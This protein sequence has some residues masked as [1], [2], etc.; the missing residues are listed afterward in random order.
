M[1][2]LLYGATGWIGFQ[3]FQLLKE[4]NVE[5]V[6]SKVR[7]ENFGDIS[8]ELNK[9]KPTHVL[10]AA[11]LTGPKN[12]DWCED[13]KDQVMSVNVIGTSVLA[14]ECNKRD[15]HLTFI[16][17]G[18]IYKYDEQHPIGFPGF[19][20]EDKPNFDES[21]YSKTKIMVQKILE[22]YNNV[23]ILRIRM[24]LAD[25]LHSRN[26]I[27]K[28]T[29]YEKVINIPNSMTVLSELLPIA[30]DMSIKSKTGTYNFTNPGAISHNQILTLYKEY[31]DPS[32]TWQNF[33]VEE[34]DKIL[35]AARSNN[36]LDVTK[37]TSEYHVDFI[38]VAIV[39]LFERMKNNVQ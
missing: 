4:K 23:L 13:H 33:T 34:Q 31:I 18:C 1:K 2:V 19:T 27:T 28:I 15:I 8:K 29:K 38:D 21:F 36:T 6:P 24:P 12:I 11:G 10:L 25:N 14:D 32:F 16:G 7:L 35:K 39:K 17:T 22:E 26:F 9:V 30:V 3:I 37:L 5:V 20:E